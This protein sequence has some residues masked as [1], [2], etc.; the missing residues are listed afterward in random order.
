MKWPQE[1]HVIHPSGRYYRRLTW[2]EISLLQGFDPEWFDMALVNKDLAQA[3][4][5]N[6]KRRMHQPRPA[7]QPKSG[8]VH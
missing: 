1:A 2:A 7:R 8:T 6:V 3:L 4:Q 5:P